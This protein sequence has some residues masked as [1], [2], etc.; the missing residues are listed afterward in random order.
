[1][2][3]GCFGGF[4]VWELC[5]TF[6]KHIVDFLTA[7]VTRVKLCY[8]HQHSP[9]P[10]LTLSHLCSHSTELLRVFVT[11][12][13]AA[14]ES[15]SDQSPHSC[16]AGTTPS[17]RCLEFPLQTVK[18]SHAHNK[19]HTVASLCLLPATVQPVSNLSTP[20]P[21]VCFPQIFAFQM[22]Q[23][24]TINHWFLLTTSAQE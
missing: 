22:S 11:C 21:Q 24:L 12:V 23:L 13:S 19:S 1:M 4:N 16:K 5:V 7:Q 14:P 15:R 17:V 8:R 20:L 10:L 3:C 18:G 2:F 6:Q 9:V